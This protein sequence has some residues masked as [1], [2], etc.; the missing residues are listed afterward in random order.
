MLSYCAKNLLRINLAVLCLCSSV[1]VIAQDTRQAC[2]AEIDKMRQIYVTILRKIPAMPPLAQLSSG[3]QTSLNAAETSREVGDFKACVV[4]MK[5][6]I[7]IV[8]NY[9]N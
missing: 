3:I 1:T 2:Q 8:Q 7:S 6:Q 5:G 9:A 4:N